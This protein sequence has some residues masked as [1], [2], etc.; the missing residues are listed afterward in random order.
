MKSSCFTLAG[1]LALAT[2]AHAGSPIPPEASFVAIGNTSNDS[3][4]GQWEHRQ[5]D[6][7]AFVDGAAGAVLSFDV[8]NDLPGTGSTAT[9][10]PTNAH[11]SFAQADGHYFLNF[12]YYLVGEPGTPEWGDSSVHLRDV[13]LVIDGVVWRDQYLSFGNDLGDALLGTAG[14]GVGPGYNI[15]GQTGFEARTYVLASTVPEPGAPALL[16]AG[17]ASLVL[18]QR[19]VRRG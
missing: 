17:A 2:A 8:A 3:N 13:E 11:L 7:S 9:N 14:D 1:L 15:L 10:L 12:E 5:M 4:P 6:V 16:L 18:L 19:R